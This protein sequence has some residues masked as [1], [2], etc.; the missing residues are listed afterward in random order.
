MDPAAARGGL[1]VRRPAG[2]ARA[3]RVD[4]EDVGAEND[5]RVFGPVGLDLGAEGAS[6]IAISI[7]AELLAYV[8]GREPGHLRGRSEAIHGG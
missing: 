2:A 5:P 7:V 3:H 6:Q 1:S 8:S 4:L